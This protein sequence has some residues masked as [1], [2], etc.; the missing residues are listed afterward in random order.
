[1]LP[2]DLEDLRNKQKEMSL[3]IV[4]AYGLGLLGI[5]CAGDHAGWEGF[6]SPREQIESTGKRQS[7]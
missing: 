3:I 4:S 6:L 5:K 7:T 1:M 2:K